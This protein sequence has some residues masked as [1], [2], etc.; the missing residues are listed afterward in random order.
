M[1][2][3]ISL[4]FAICIC[5]VLS[6]SAAYRAQNAAPTDPV[7]RAMVDEL[8][9]SVSELQ[10]KDLEKPYFIQ[11]NV[12]DQERYRTTATFGALTAADTSRARILQAQVRV[13]DYDFDNSEFVAGGGFQGAPAAGVTTQTVIDDDY[14]SIRHALWLTTD[15]AYK[16]SVEQLARKR[17]FV[18]NKVRGDQ[19]PDFSKE[20]AVTAV[21]ARRGLQVDKAR[22]EK[23]V[24]EW[25]AIFR[26]FP[27]IQE[28]NVV[29]EAQVT[30]RYLV[31]SEGTRTLQPSMLVTIEVDAGTEAV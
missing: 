15:S 19:I 6:S 13:G 18:Q 21:D 17:A 10:F 7:M 9:R 28:S 1:R 12:L 14:E 30:H 27:E 24:R 29:L 20:N 26:D 23:Q 8:K 5:L 31:N 22:W 25:S 11:Y 16:Q 3:S 4:K 2:R